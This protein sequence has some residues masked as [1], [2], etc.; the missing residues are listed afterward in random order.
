MPQPYPC[1]STDND[2]SGDGG[3]NPDGSQFIPAETDFTLQNGDQWFYN[4]GAGGAWP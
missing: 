1:W 4:E 2:P 3:G